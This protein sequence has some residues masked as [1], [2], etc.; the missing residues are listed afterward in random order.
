MVYGITPD[1]CSDTRLIPL[2]FRVEPFT[3]SEK[4]SRIRNDDPDV[5][6]S[7]PINNG[8]VM[9]GVKSFTGIPLVG[10]IAVAVFPDV[11]IA[12]LLPNDMKVVSLLTASSGTLLIIFKSKLD[13]SINTVILLVVITVLL[14][15]VYLSSMPWLFCIV[16][17]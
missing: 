14:V 1:D 5:S 3:V 7:K 17:I 13:R 15:K 16:N 6:K 8:G 10:G 4:R 12:A 11:S 2:K 9:S